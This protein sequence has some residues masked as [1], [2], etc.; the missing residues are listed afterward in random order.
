MKKII[1][2]PDVINYLKESPIYNT[3][4]KLLERKT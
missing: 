4:L 3:Y 2:H 1:S